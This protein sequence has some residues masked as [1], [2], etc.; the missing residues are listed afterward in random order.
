MIDSL[1]FVQGA[2]A[3][4]DFVQELTHYHIEGGFIKAFN[5]MLG[6]C[7]PIDLDLDVKPNATQF[8]KA[9]QSC[10]ETA[11]LHLTDKGRL[12]IKSGPFRAFVDC[13]PGDFP[14]V[15]PEGR[16]IPLNGGLLKVI[17]TLAPFI[18]EDASRQ[19][20]RGILLR[21]QSAYVTNNI[22]L[23]QH[24]LGYEFPVDLNIPRAAVVELI[25]I[26]E[27]PV[28]LQV[29]ENNVTFHFEGDRWLRTQT[30]DLSWPDVDRVL[31]VGTPPTVPAPQALWE[32]AEDLAPFVDDLGRLFLS[33][34]KASTSQHDGEGASVDIPEIQH[35][36]CFHFKQLGLVSKVVE[37][38]DFSQ[39]PKP[40]P[41]LGKDLRG[42]IIGMKVL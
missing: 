38:I 3:K 2:V 19:W 4:K 9:I 18:A 1:K 25:R 23:I 37:T 28:S 13:I 40:C 21:G 8:N 16:E 31:S 20:A 30:Y 11:A 26:G 10:K 39:Y 33:A 29:G 22:V 17:K 27:E 36:G 24:W 32:A 14:E 12:A 15:A 6:L 34:G 5:G 41:F 7:C 42:V 35:N